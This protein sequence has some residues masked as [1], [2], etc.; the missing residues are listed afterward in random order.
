M[1]L[2]PRRF[3][4]GDR[5]ATWGGPDEPV[6]C[7]DVR[8]AF[9]CP[10]CCEPLE[11]RGSAFRCGTGHSF[12]RAKEGYVNLLPG[13]RLKGRPAGDN[14]SMVRARRQLFDAGLYQPIVDRVAAVAAETAPL[15]VLDAGCGEGSY[16]AAATALAGAEGW[17][18][19][20]SKAAVK[21][22][23][24]R[25]P[26]HHYA[27]SST[28]SLPFADGLFDVAINVFA[29]RDFAEMRRVLSTSGVAIVVTPGPDHLRE[30][31]AT[32]YDDARRHMPQVDAEDAP[33][34]EEAVSFDLAL[35]TPQH[36]LALLQ[37]TPFWW[38]ASEQRR[39][40]VA[41]SLTS[42]TVDM[43]LSVHSAES[44]G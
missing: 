6:H 29:P 26:D 16:L 9:R 35:A 40:E 2:A 24:R 11:D 39:D 20:V 28:Y 10:R 33:V 13:G 44:G 36:R 25:N 21:L 27:V 37:M 38:S 23:A 30:L 32:V 8:P 15:F 42:V 22:A 5:T 7:C 19:D 31:K 12:D 34:R 14:D 18:I 43:R 3:R 1:G 4:C 41:A 17:G